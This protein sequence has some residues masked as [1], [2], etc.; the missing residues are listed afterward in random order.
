MKKSKSRKVSKC[1]QCGGKVKHMASG[2]LNNSLNQISQT[3][4]GALMAVPDPTG[5]TKA[6]G[7]GLEV[8]PMLGKGVDSIIDKTKVQDPTTLQDFRKNEFMNSYKDVPDILK[9]SPLAPLL[10]GINAMG[11]KHRAAD[12]FHKYNLNQQKQAD[13]ATQPNVN[14]N[15]FGSYKKG[16]KTQGNAFLFDSRYQNAVM[17]DGGGITDFIMESIVRKKLEESKNLNFVDRLNHPNNYPSLKNPD[18]AYSTEKMASSDN[19]VYPT[20]IYQP[21]GTLKELSPQD[22]YE[23]AK[24][25]NNFISFET[26]SQAN[27]F[28]FNN[29]KRPYPQLWNEVEKSGEY[30][31]S[32]KHPHFKEGG[33]TFN[34]AKYGEIIKKMVEGGDSGVPYADHSHSPFVESGDSPIVKQPASTFKGDQKVLSYQ[35]YLNHLGANIVEDGIWGKETQKAYDN[36]YTKHISAKTNTRIN[37]SDYEDHTSPGS[38]QGVYTSSSQIQPT[39]QS[40]ISWIYDAVK[41]Q[42]TSQKNKPLSKVKQLPQKESSIVEDMLGFN[43]NDILNQYK[44]NKTQE[45]GFYE[46]MFNQAKNR[47]EDLK[48]TLSKMPKDAQEIVKQK[49]SN[50]DYGTKYK[51][52]YFIYSKENSTFYILDSNHH[53]LDYS[54]AGRGQTPGD[55]QNTVD[56]RKSK[57]NGK[58]TTPAG[59]YAIGQW[60]HTPEDTRDYDSRFYPFSYNKNNKG[61]LGLHGTYK[62]EPSRQIIMNDPAIKQKLMSYGC[63]NIPPEFINKHS[64]NNDIVPGDSLFITKEPKGEENLEQMKKGGWIQNAV[65][66]AHKGYEIG[67]EYEVDDLELERLKTAGYKFD[68]I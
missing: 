46:S 24:K 13:L 6:V 22:A 49:A 30:A 52:N 1:Y 31:G 36:L 54:I 65:N 17:G 8:L 26:P 14:P 19:I 12:D 61:V 27:W 40:Y 47:Q 53:L 42:T 18:G 9:F 11:A 21:D 68:I 5:V 23:Y 37:E 25:N 50:P 64:Y 32:S 59:S 43:P 57:Y 4:G 15:P 55:F 44:E 48:I 34:E 29:Y 63:I 39:N 51:G 16:G 62:G 2:G 3:A 66:P 60:S 41:K 10:T 38:T 67:K 7:L 20:I 56:I 35:K 28:A 58:A 45:K 33:L